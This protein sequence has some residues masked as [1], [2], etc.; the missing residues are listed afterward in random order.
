M[1]LLAYDVRRDGNV[2]YLMRRDLTKE[3]S[4]LLWHDIGYFPDW[5]DAVQTRDAIQAGES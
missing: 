2:A 5:H 4:D 1:R 3:D